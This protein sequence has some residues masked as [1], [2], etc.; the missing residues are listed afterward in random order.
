MFNIFPWKILAS[1]VTARRRAVVN[2]V[3]Q[4]ELLDDARRGQVIRLAHRCSQTVIL[5]DA[6]AEGVHIHHDRV[7]FPDGIRQRDLTALGKAC[8]DDIFGNKPR[9]VRAAAV[10]FG[11]IL[12][13]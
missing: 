13:R 12:A 9:H 7:F 2:G 8:R 3:Q 11:G 4:V 1:E 10:Y 6:G 5:A